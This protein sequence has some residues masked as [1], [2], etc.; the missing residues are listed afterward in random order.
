[1]KKTTKIDKEILSAKYEDFRDYVKA[2]SKV[3]E[4]YQKN[5]AIKDVRQREKELINI[6]E[7]LVK[8]YN[9]V[10]PSFFDE[11]F[12]FDFS[13]LVKNVGQLRATQEEVIM[14]IC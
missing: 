10:K 11:N 1:M 14:M 5:K 9:I 3:F 12:V 6:S 7:S 8:C 13:Y 2:I 4:T